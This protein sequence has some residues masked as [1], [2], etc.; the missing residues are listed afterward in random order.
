MSLHFIQRTFPNQIQFGSEKLHPKSA[1]T[2]TDSEVLL[3]LYKIGY[4]KIL[5]ESDVLAEQRLK[6]NFEVNI[7]YKEKAD[8]F[9]N[10]FGEKNVS[11][12]R[13]QKGKKKRGLHRQQFR[14]RKVRDQ[15]SSEEANGAVKVGQERQKGE[16][17][18]KG[19]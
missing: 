19:D 2:L 6:A 10:I 18:G 3:W 12:F 8:K 4:V 11:D 1:L 13:G 9:M 17:K 16:T 7:F 14:C 5:A 15:Q